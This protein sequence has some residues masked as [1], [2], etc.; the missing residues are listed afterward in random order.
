MNLKL[1]IRR[2]ADGVVAVA[3]W[4]D[5]DFNVFWWEEGNAACDCN[6]E[7]FFQQILNETS[8]SIDQLHCSDGR[9]SVRCSDADTGVVLYDE[10]KQVKE[11]T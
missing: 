6:R 9:Y 10:F 1:E 3:V 11:P 2:N 5:W 4:P 8:D 7:L